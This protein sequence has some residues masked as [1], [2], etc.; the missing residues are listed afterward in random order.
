MIDILIPV[1][2]RP[3]NVQPLMASLEG[4]TELEHRVIFMVTPG[5]R[6]QIEA[7]EAT[8]HTVVE[9]PGRWH[10]YPAKMNAGFITGSNPWVFLAADDIEFRPG[11]DTRAMEAADGAGVVGID[12]M[13]NV[14][15]RRGVWSTHPFVSR[16]YVEEFGGCLEGAG[17]LLSCAYDHNY[18][19]REVCGIA[20]YR[21]RWVFVRGAKIKHRH[22]GWQ[23]RGGDATYLKGQRQFARDRQVFYRRAPHWG[24][25]GLVPAERGKCKPAS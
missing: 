15:V 21:E 5:D 4:N 19:E 12:D 9:V 3:W 2:G 13:L 22:G 8:G 25:K 23:N 1:L 6:A 7:C 14:W 20:Q 18:C 10:Q 24:C 16:A 11:W 17:Q